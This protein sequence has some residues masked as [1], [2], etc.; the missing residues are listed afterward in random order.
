MGELKRIT[1]NGSSLFAIRVKG[2]TF[3]GCSLETMD[4]KKYGILD[5]SGKLLFIIKLNKKDAEELYSTGKVKN[6]SI[7]IEHMVSQ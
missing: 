5:M 7:V 2:K 1:A 6:K 3:S 4:G